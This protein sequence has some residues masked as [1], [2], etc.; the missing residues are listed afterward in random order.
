M[1]GCLIY[2]ILMSGN[3]LIG[4]WCRIHVWKCSDWTGQGSDVG[5]LS[6]T[7][8]ILV[9]YLSKSYLNTGERGSDVGYLSDTCRILVG[10]LS[11]S[12][13]NTGERGSDVGYLSFTCRILVGYLSDT[14]WILARI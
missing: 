10:Y 12:Y 3:A 6:D 5:Y 14:C 4:Q 2:R 7:C 11:K 8:R 9:G 1:N 13:L